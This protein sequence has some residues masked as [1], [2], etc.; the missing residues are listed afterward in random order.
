MKKLLTLMSAA[1]VATAA[2]AQPASHLFDHGNY[3]MFIHWGLY[4]KI[5]NHWNGKTYYGA[6][7]WIM[8]HN[9]AGTDRDEYRATARDFN[10]TDFDAAAIARLAKDAGMKYVIIT[11]KHHDGFAMY[12]SQCSDFDIIDSTPFGRDPMRELADACRAEGLGFGFYYSHNQDWTTPGATNGPRVD[13][14]GNARDFDHYFRTKC[15]PQVDEITR[16]YGDMTLIWF[17]TPGGKLTKAHAKELMETV[18]KNQPGA[19]IS[20]RVGFGM[21]DYETLGDMEVPHQNIAG[22]WESVDVTND[23]WGYAWY[24]NNWKTPEQIVRYLVSTVARGGTYMLNLGLDG[25]GR[26]PEFAAQ[27]LRAAGRWIAAYPMT[28]YGA[29]PSPWGHALPWGDAVR[30]ANRLYLTVYDWPA[31]GKLYVP[32]LRTEVDGAALLLPDGKRR[33]AKFTRQG[34]LLEVSV[35]QVKPDRLYGVVELTLAADTVDV[36]PAIVLDPNVGLP[37]LSV[38]FATLTKCNRRKASWM[39]KFGEW[40]HT[41]C[42]SDLHRGGSISWTI[43]V[44]KPVTLQVG[45][46]GRGTGPGVWRLTT[47]SGTTL[48]NRQRVA[49]LFAVRPLGWLSLAP[50]RHTLT[51]TMPEGASAPSDVASLSLVPVAL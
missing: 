47:D 17:D 32:G 41:Q 49:A 16:N 23:S 34:N 12:D 46:R 3:A 35:P 5:A 30:Q 36:D 31:S 11:S 38:N 18:R 43:D 2:F 7:E 42:V 9:M 24:D 48:Q 13:P 29:E 15:L 44:V 21:G 10:P 45:I 33:K 6:S 25:Q 1:L 20:G 22:R 51:L 4:S 50:G 8:N 40:K 37:D 14:Q 26:I 27:T 28:V 19:L 39:E